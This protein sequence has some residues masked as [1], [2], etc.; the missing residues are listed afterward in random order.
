MKT[1]VDRFIEYIKIETTSYPEIEGNP[2]PS[3]AMQMDF[4]HFMADEMKA[5]GIEEVE[6]DKN[7]FVFGTIPATAEGDIPVIA[8]LAHMDTIS[9]ISGKDI[10]PSIVHYEG[11]DVILNKELGI[12]MEEKMFPFIKNYV[13]QDLIVTDG[14]TL[15]GADDKAGIVEIF[16]LAEKLLADKS[17][18]HGKIRICLTPDEEIGTG[19]LNCDVEKLGANFGYTIDGGAVGGLEYENFNAASAKVIV[20]GSNIHPGSSKNKMKNS[21]HIAMEFHGMLPPYEQPANTEGYEGFSHL[22][23]MAG[24]VEQTTMDYIIR[25][26]DAAKFDIK[27][28]RFEKIAA[29]LNE[30]YGEGTI[31]L[32]LSDSYRNM[33]EVVEPYMFLID[34]AKASFSENGVTPVV[35]A[36]RGGTD[37][38]RLSYM[39]LPCPNLSTGGHNAHGKYEFVPVQSLEKMV[40]VLATLV[41]KF[42]K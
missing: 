20:N 38:A 2:C 5:I 35:S 27:K 9:D 6:V 39:G 4:A 23:H 12:V 30:K 10:K 24:G 29:Y 33:K 37:G 42:V 21:L 41:Q 13:G 16:A 31:D 28:A 36:I 3:S 25:D 7:G 19:I 40:D 11:G 34:Y 26:H 8:L 14:T 22:N 32:R 18:P 17:I 1:I 15:L